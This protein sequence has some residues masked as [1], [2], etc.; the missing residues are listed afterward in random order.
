[1]GLFEGGNMQAKEFTMGLSGLSVMNHTSATNGLLKVTA[2]RTYISTERS[3]IGA[4][5]NRL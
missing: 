1:M 5:Q 3:H 2:A 4:M